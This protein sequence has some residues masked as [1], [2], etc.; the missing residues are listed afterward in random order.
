MSDEPARIDEL[1]DA[2]VEVRGALALARGDGPTAERLAALEAAVVAR[3]GGGGPGDGGG[4][5]GEPGTAGGAASA[6][7]GLAAALAI[8]G[9]AIAVGIVVVVSQ[10][11]PDPP[12][13]VGV[14]SVEA[15]RAPSAVVPPSPSSSDAPATVR[16]DELP[17]ASALPT[18]RP[19]SSAPRAVPSA[20]P[21]AAPPADVERAELALLDAAQASLTTR[22]GEALALCEQ[23]RRQHASGSLAQ[24]RE[25]IALDAL[26]RL[27]QRAEAE[28]RAAAFHA[29]HPGSG[30]ARRI[31]A[32]LAR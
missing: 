20:V 6:P 15:P 21:P 28:R 31:D 5:H 32:L 26:L 29:A 10:R 12:A 1:E 7:G 8:A 3:T 19:A 16:I 17:A 25:V 30:H 23:H 13:A 11:T 14:R 2:P 9:A 22:P 27:G 4:T 24:E 18:P